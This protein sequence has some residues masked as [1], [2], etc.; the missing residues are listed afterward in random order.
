MDAGVMADAGTDGNLHCWQLLSLVVI[1]PRS[2]LLVFCVSCGLK[3]Q[4]LRVRCPVKL[5]IVLFND[6][7]ML[8]TK[9]GRAEHF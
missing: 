9:L 8:E 4:Q 1:H 3:I 2:H 7:L 6:R 5:E